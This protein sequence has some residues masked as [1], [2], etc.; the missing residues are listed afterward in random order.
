[1]ALVA[2]NGTATTFIPDVFVY[3]ASFVNI[4]FT[5]LGPNQELEGHYSLSPSASSPSGHSW[6][7]RTKIKALIDF[8][9][10]V[11]VDQDQDMFETKELSRPRQD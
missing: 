3:F 4:Y 11:W 6:Y 8:N 1:M 9:V 7:C 5:L 10:V 2:V